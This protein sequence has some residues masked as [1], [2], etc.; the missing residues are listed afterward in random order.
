M[1]LGYS[2]AQEIAADDFGILLLRQLYDDPTGA[3]LFFEKVLEEES[4]PSWAYMFLTHPHP[5]ERI[6]R[7]QRGL[8]E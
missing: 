2:R 4:P 5:Q 7:L 3:P 6:P 1:E 8:A